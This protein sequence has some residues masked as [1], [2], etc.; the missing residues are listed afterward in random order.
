[1]LD[2]EKKSETHLVPP[3][4][5]SPRNGTPISQTATAGAEDNK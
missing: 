2:A 3:D 1:M 4:P 5:Y